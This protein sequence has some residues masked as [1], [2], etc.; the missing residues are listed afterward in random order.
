MRGHIAAATGL[1]LA[2]LMTTA[3]DR[4]GADGN[5]AANE[6]AATAAAAGNEANAAGEEAPRSILRPDVVPVHAP[7]PPPEPIKA[8][9]AFGTSGLAL[10]DAGKQAVDALLAQQVA[11][12]GGPIILRGSTD[13]RGTDGDNLVASRK[14]A[15]AVRAY[16]IE[17]GVAPERIT[18]VALGETRPIAPNAMLDGSDDPEG[19]AKNRRVDV[20]IQPRITVKLPEI[21]DNAASD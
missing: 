3:C 2:C 6:A 5:A 21:P 14:R 12:S 9:I 13:S 18:L 20:E 10:D 16:M 15:E 11:V 7:E 4:R 8:V 1:T 17:R 19:R